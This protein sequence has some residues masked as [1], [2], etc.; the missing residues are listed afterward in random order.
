M[1][2]SLKIFALIIAAVCAFSML[3]AC[4]GAS[5]SEG[6]D[7][8]VEYYVTY[9]GTKIELGAKSASTLE[10]LGEPKDTKSLG[11]CGGFGLQTR[12]TYSNL[13]L[14]TIKNDSGETIDQITI[15]SDQVQTPKGVYIGMSKSDVISA[16]GNPTSQSDTKLEY[17]NGSL[18]LKFGLDSGEV[19]TIDFMR[20]TQK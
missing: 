9:K 8:A 5:N 2:K 4:N 7:S 11:D 14:Y 13:T 17:V 16:Y 12:Y 1:K 18:I 3:V 10:A 19:D 20:V 6:G 15:T